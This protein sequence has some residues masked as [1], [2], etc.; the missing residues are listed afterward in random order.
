MRDVGRAAPCKPVASSLQQP[1]S[2]MRKYVAFL[3][4]LTWM[5]P[6]CRHDIDTSPVGR[7]LA[8]RVTSITLTATIATYGFPENLLFRKMRR[9]ANNLVGVG[10]VL[11]RGSVGRDVGL[12]G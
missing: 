11:R 9:Q 7:K 3:R 10:L 5:R 12:S 6:C 4:P 2:S 8:G 1:Q